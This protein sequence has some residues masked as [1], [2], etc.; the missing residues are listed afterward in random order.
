MKLGAPTYGDLN[1]IVAFAMTGATTPYR[2]PSSD[3]LTYRKFSVNMI[4]FPRLHFFMYG[5]APIH[6]RGYE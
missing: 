3:N 1:H 4:P 5:M 2:Y 6:P